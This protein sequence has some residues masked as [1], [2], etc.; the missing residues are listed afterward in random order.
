[1]LPWNKPFRNANCLIFC[2]KFVPLVYLL[3]DK[4]F[5]MGTIRDIMR[6]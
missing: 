6:K 5:L 3:L 4:E 1:M 2:G